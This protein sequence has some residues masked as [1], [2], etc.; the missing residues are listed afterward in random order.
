MARHVA[1][2]SCRARGL[3]SNAWLFPAPAR[4]CARD[5]RI[6]AISERA[7]ARATRTLPGVEIEARAADPSGASPRRLAP[8]AFRFQSE[9]ESM[10]MAHARPP[11]LCGAVLP[12][13]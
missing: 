4:F 13:V 3:R 12:I 7:R 11:R 1:A 6:E 5:A 2:S 8:V 10:G 9:P